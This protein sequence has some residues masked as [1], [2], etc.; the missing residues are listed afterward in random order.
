LLCKIL[1]KGELNPVRHGR[2]RGDITIGNDVWIGVNVVIL[3]GVTIGDGAVVGSGAVVTKDVP[4]YAI[5]GGVPARVIRK[6][7]SDTDISLLLA[8][9]WWDWEQEKIVRNL[10]HFY[11]AD[12]S[13][14]EFIRLSRMECA[15]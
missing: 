15:E 8:E 11:N 3:S 2:S 14:L 5:V 9:R 1:G 7:F 10:K 12:L 4:A 6:R 13:V